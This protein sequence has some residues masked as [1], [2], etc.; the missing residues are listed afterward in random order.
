MPIYARVC[1]ACAVRFETFAKMVESNMLRCPRCG[2]PVA[3]D[4][5]AQGAPRMPDHDLH[6]TRSESLE[7]RCQ[8]DE[9]KELRQTFGKDGAGHAWQ[10]DGSVR[11]EHRSDAKKFFRKYINIRKE[12]ESAPDPAPANGPTG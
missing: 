7:F 6:G 1:R 8:P 3:T 4:F 9:V 2:G 11:F 5:A 12:V 10:D